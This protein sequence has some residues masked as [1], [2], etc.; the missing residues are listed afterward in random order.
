MRKDKNDAFK[1]RKSGKS[2]KQIKNELGIPLATLSDWFKNEKWSEKIYKKL[3]KKNILSGKLRMIKLDAI[4]GERLKRVYEE[5]RRDAEVEFQA[6][7]HH[8]LFVSGVM[9]YWGEGDKASKNGFRISNADPAIVKIF[10][11]FLRKVCS[12]EEQRIRAGLLIYPDL[13]ALQCLTY[14]SKALGLSKSNFTKSIVIQGRHKTRR[15]Q[16]GICTLTFSS[17]FL[18]EKMLI[19]ISLFGKELAE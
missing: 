1:L 4:R 5:A 11:N 9:I 10:L 18:K 7:K 13:D 17:R 12:A 3:N 15:V 19:W 6:L 8:P 16:Y 2:Y 14:W